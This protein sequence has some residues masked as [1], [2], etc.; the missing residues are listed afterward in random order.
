MNDS[1]DS[2]GAVDEKGTAIGTESKKG[3]QAG[4]DLGAVDDLPRF[5]LDDVNVAFIGACQD[6][7]A[8]K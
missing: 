1:D 3:D 6:V 4:A 7:V 5:G 8:M 2:V